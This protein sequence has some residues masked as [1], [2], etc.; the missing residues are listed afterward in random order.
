MLDHPNRRQHFSNYLYMT[1]HLV[2]Q[3]LGF[4]V[5]L[6]E[7]LLVLLQGAT[8]AVMLIPIPQC[9]VPV[10]HNALIWQGCLASLLYT[11]CNAAA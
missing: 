9:L 7:D 3:L 6:P 1:S 11:S 2:T 8:V 4:T 10:C 5:V